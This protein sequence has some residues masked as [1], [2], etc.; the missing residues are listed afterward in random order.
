MQGLIRL[1]LVAVTA[2]FLSA[3]VMAPAIAQSTE[4]SAPAVKIDR[5]KLLVQPRNK[6]GTVEQVAFFDD[7]VLWARE[8]QQAFYGKMSGA[9]RQMRSGSALAATWTL[10]LL[11][12]G[13]GVFHA[14]GPGHGKAVIGAA[15][16]EAIGDGCHAV[17]DF[18]G[19]RHIYPPT[20]HVA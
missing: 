17:T 10:M 16:I 9:L 13:Y 15:A 18:R 11:S 3:A 1:V 2:I 14:A 12:F 7:P 20:I 6:D 4:Q 8:M 19:N 5:K